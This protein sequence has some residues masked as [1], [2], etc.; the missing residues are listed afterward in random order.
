MEVANKLNI[1]SDICDAC[2]T[3]GGNDDLYQKYLQIMIYLMNRNINISDISI[4]ANTIDDINKNTNNNH[5]K[6][7]TY[8]AILSLFQL[9]SADTAE[10]E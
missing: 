5:L 7:Y 9:D 10:I 2:C 6:C 4:I 3:F 1:I 8:K